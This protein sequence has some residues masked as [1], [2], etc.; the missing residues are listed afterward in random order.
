M[1]LPGEP[2]S[3]RSR[4]GPPGVGH[5]PVASTAT[6]QRD[7][8]SA[9]RSS[10]GAPVGTPA[11]WA[12]GG[13][14]NHH[15]KPAQTHPKRRTTGRATGGLTTRAT[16][17]VKPCPFV[18]KR[19]LAA[20]PELADHQ[21]ITA[22]M[23]TVFPLDDD[24]WLALGPHLPE[25]PEATP[26]GSGA[27]PAAFSWEQRTKSITLLPGGIDAYQDVLFEIA[28]H[29]DATQPARAELHDWIAGPLPG[30]RA[31]GGPG[32]RVPRPSRSAAPRLRPRRTHAGRRPMDEGTGPRLPPR[33]HP[34]PSPLPRRD[35]RPSR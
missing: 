22:P 16:L 2:R 19:E 7:T 14:S 32:R 33:P 35:A 12:W 15:A 11:S 20:I 5:H 18:S 24:E 9:T 4:R 26:P 1:D 17:R 30:L 13:S 29:I 3:V 6:R 8:S 23:G 34:R 10:S 28:S 27:W 25:P 31:P 21:I